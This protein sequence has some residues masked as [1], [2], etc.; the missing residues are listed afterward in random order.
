M[1]VTTYQCIECDEIINNPVC[2]DC[3]AGQMRVMIREYHP[4]LARKIRGFKVEGDTCCILCGKN[5][6]LC[7][8]CFSKGIYEYLQ[9]KNEL[10]AKEFL[11]RFDFDL[12][13]SWVDLS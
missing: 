6:G 8:H 3:L 7:A 1:R 2:S 11:N 13:K 10:V 4:A 5:M 12:R 9:Q